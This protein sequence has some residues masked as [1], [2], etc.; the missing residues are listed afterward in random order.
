M[1]FKRF[2][3]SL[4]Y[5]NLIQKFFYLRCFFFYKHFVLGFFKSI[6]CLN[7]IEVLEYLLMLRTGIDEEKKKKSIS[8]NSIFGKKVLRDKVLKNKNF[9]VRGKSISNCKK[10]KNE[11]CIKPKLKLFALNIFKKLKQLKRLRSRY[12]FFVFFFINFFNVLFF[13]ILFFYHKFFI[14]YFKVLFNL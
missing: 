9:L 13:W 10:Y 4:Q 7:D 3:L 1:V 6:L 11:L 5:K 2:S 12:I 14:F 8:R